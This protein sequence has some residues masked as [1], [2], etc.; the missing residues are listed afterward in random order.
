MSG[1]QNK[2]NNNDDLE[3]GKASSFKKREK[4]RSN[5]GSKASIRVSAF[6]MNLQKEIT[7]MRL[8]VDED[9]ELDASEI[10]AAI[11]NLASTNK[12]NMNLKKLLCGMLVFSLL[13]VGCVFGATI[14]AARLSKETTIDLSSGIVYA[15]GTHETMKTESVAFV[16]EDAN[17]GT[18]TND[19]LNSLKEISISEDG[20]VKFTV[21]GYARRR[22]ISADGIEE[23]IKLLIDGG[24]TITYDSTGSIIDATGYAKELLEYAYPPE[25]GEYDT[26]TTGDDDRRHLADVC[27]GE[28]T[29]IVTSTCR[30]TRGNPC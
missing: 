11:D 16:T 3:Y 20:N 25:D 6:P 7:K 10:V 23:G 21:K 26:A 12:D 8:D 30:G 4:N 29:T 22:A 14:A 19:Q 28:S 27:A 24:G 17:I 5:T 9:G 2:I 18:M 15:K 1:E 13:L